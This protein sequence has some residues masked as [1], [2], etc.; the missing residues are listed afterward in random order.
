MK[1]FTVIAN[2]RD[3]KKLQDDQKNYVNGMNGKKTIQLMLFY[4]GKCK[5]V[6]KQNY[7]VCNGK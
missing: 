4:V 3:I 2:Q 5:I 6:Q 7:E 1:L